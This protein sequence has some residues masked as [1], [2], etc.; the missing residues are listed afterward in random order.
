MSIVHVTI[1]IAAPPQKV[2]RTVMDPYRLRDWVTIHRQLSKVPD[3]PIAEGARMDQVLHMH[4]ISFTV[5]WT[6]VA[7]RPPFEAEWMGRGPAMSHARIH[8]GL[9]GERDGPTTFDYTNEFGAPGGVLGKIASRVVI[10]QSS[11]RE[12]HNSLQQLKE[13]I[14]KQDPRHNDA[15]GV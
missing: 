9:R 6:L 1:E 11:E 5:H 13:L 8:Y 10:G 14:E 12:A 3:D 4:G 15:T 7:V 2:F